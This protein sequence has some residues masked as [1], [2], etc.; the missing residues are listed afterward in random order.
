[1]SQGQ[2]FP[3]LLSGMQIRSRFASIDA[4]DGSY[5]IS[6]ATTISQIVEEEDL[7]QDV[8]QALKNATTTLATARDLPAMYIPVDSL[9]GYRPL[10]SI[11]EIMT[12]RA[13]SFSLLSV[14]VAQL[15]QHGMI[16]P[17]AAK[18][19][20]LIVERPVCF[21]NDITHS[22]SSFLC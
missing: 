6:A 7:Q 14:P 11:L 9:S 2:K 17:P 1:M 15:P 4:S 5:T 3:Q 8:R 12:S 16:N 20:I 13:S 18:T 10:A 19:F 22:C 21:L